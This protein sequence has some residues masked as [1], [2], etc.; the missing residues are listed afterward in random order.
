L[1]DAA[2]PDVLFQIGA[3]GHVHVRHRSVGRHGERLLHREDVVRFAD[4]PAF[5]ERRGR[6]QLGPV[7]FERAAI[8]P[9]RDRVDV[10]LLQAHVVGE[11]ADG[12]VGAP[13]RHLPR[14]DLLFDGARPRTRVLVGQER[15]RRHRARPVALDAIPEEDRRDV[16]AEGRRSRRERGDRADCQAESDEYCLHVASIAPIS[17]G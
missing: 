11:L 3:D 5:R 1:L 17:L 12:R 4:R 8:D 14:R 13:G 7:A 6:R 9:R 16:L 15:H 2:N 10:G